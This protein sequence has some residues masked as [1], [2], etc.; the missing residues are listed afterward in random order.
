M[1]IQQLLV[2]PHLI[3]ICHT[4]LTKIWVALW[5]I[6]KPCKLILDP[7]PIVSKRGHLVKVRLPKECFDF[8]VAK[9]LPKNYLHVLGF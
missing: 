2:C 6:H 8:G 7:L 9:L 5:V 3:Y 4:I 1:I